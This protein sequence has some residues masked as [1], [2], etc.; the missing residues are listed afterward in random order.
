MARIYATSAEYVTYTGQTAPADIAALLARASRFLDSNAFRLCWYEADT[1]TGMP[2][3]AVVLA[4]FSDAVCA[5]VQW[6]EET[7]DELGV[8]GNWSSVKIGSVALSGA[9]SSAGGSAAVGGREI[10][11]AA[12]EA[13]RSPDLTADLFILGLVVT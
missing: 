7:G 3:N 1:V 6:W 12:L 4:A 5:Q 8:A 2:T 13:L 11:G 10:A 9:S